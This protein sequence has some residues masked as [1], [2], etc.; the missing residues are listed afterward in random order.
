MTDQ[1]IVYNS[2]KDKSILQ[3]SHYTKTHESTHRYLAYR[4]IPTIVRKYIQGKN[5][6]DYG[7]GTGYSANFLHKIGFEVTGVDVSKEMLFQARL[8]YPSFP[9]FPVEN[10]VIPIESSLFDLVFSSFVLFEIGTKNAII[11]HLTEAKR[12]MKDDGIFVAVTGSQYLHNASKKWLNFRVDFPE[13][14]NPISGD[15]VKLHLNGAD[16]D[17]TD[18]Y[19]TE[20]DYRQCFLQAGLELIEIHYPLGDENEPYLWKDEIKSSPFVILVARKSEPTFV[21]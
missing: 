7:T 9:F 10:G 20:T 8:A 12:V 18:Y 3:A 6:L 16:L 5:A 4:D 13:N 1:A 2:E 15:V 17:F 19:W 21:E 14:Q 11:D